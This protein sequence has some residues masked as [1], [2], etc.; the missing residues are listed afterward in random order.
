ME[1][2]PVYKKRKTVIGWLFEISTIGFLL[3]SF[4]YYLFIRIG[5]SKQ[6]FDSYENSNAVIIVLFCTGIFTY[7]ILSILSKHPRIF[8]FPIE[9]SNNNYESLY[10]IGINIINSLKFVISVFISFMIITIINDF[11]RSL[12]ITSIILFFLLIII[13]PIVGIFKMYKLKEKNKAYS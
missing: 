5:S 4:C 13:I 6:H 8:N 1:N 12:T 7:I 2:R 9:V 11:S 10:K 3:L